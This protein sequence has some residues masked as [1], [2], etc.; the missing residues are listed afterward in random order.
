MKAPVFWNTVPLQK[1]YLIELFMAINFLI[2]ETSKA[3]VTINSK[4]ILH[5]NQE[6][7]MRSQ[8][9]ILLII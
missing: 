4:S 6:A 1:D 2:Y 9:K 8:K 3:S 5:I 7:I